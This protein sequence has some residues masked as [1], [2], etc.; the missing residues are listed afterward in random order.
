MTNTTTV[1]ASDGA[2]NQGG[3]KQVKLC[4][5]CNAEIVFCQSKKSGKWYPVNVS[6]GYHDQRFYMGHNVHRCA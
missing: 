3:S 2:V 5:K 1:W 4:N 6:R